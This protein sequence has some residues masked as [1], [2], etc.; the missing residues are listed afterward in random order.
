M[1]PIITVEGP[2]ASGKTAFAVELAQ[3]FDT[4]IISADSRQVYKYCNIGTAKPSENELWLVR[5]H[6][7]DIITPDETYNAGL[8]RK[9]ASV[10]IDELNAKGK[11]P[12]ICGG[13]GLYIKALLEGLFEADIYDKNIRTSLD[14]EL[15]SK[16]LQ[17]LYDELEDVDCNS[18][19]NISKNDK[20]R[21]LRA[22]EV[23][24]ATGIPI[25]E[26]WKSQLLEIK[27]RP[28]RI[29]LTEDRAILYERID[30]RVDEMLEAGLIEEMYSILKKG[31][32][33][34]C[35]GFIS[36]GYKEYKPFIEGNSELV[37]CSILAKQHTRNYAKRQ[38]T[39]YNK[40]SFHLTDTAFSIN[41]NM[42]A[43]KIRD[44]FKT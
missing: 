17:A 26:H 28:F 22:L 39:W 32:T 31:F 38:F 13:T 43:D 34:Q 21:I 41:I 11:I 12:I 42:V 15:Y 25:S 14:N 3:R 40:C 16:G 18:A 33:W 9:D 27:Y 5:H 10:I 19:V 35:P 37:P 29:M 1:I 30:K 20:Q 8:F 4:Q 23:Y 7:I 36:V 24:R 2:T 6:L 44:Y